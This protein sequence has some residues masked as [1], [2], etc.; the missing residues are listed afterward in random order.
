MIKNLFLFCL[1]INSYILPKK[2]DLI[3][4][5]ATF[6][7]WEIILAEPFVVMMKI[8]SSCGENY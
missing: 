4:H 5:N 3:V 6:T 7:Q 1:S 8:Y 2:V